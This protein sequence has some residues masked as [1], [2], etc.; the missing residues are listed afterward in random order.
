MEEFEVYC[1]AM[2][3]INSAIDLINR[4][5]RP[6]LRFK[7]GEEFYVITEMADFSVSIIY[8]DTIEEIPSELF[9][10]VMYNENNSTLIFMEE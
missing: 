6:G 4:N 10:E 3:N 1:H 5:T 8:F 9:Y 7:S 2:E